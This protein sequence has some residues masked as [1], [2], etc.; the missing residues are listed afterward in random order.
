[1]L[2]KLSNF[3][4]TKIINSTSQRIDPLSQAV[5]RVLGKMLRFIFFKKVI[6]RIQGRYILP[7]SICVY[8]LY[9]PPIN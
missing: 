2:P 3:I 8:K 1:M 4:D 6:L 7:A 9:F 5:P